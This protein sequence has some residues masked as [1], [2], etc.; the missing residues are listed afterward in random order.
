MQPV[1]F[2]WPMLLGIGILL[3]SMSLSAVESKDQ[4]ANIVRAKVGV[5]V[6]S[7]ERTFSA[8]GRQRLDP[9]DL[10]RLYIHTERACYIYVVHTSQLG[11]SLLNMTEPKLQTTTLI[12]PSIKTYYQIDGSH[13]RETFT[14]VCA[15]KQIPELEAM[16]HQPLDYATWQRLQTRLEEQS[17]LIIADD[18]TTIAIGGNVRGTDL[19]ASQEQLTAGAFLHRVPVSSGDGLLLRSYEFQIQN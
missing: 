15:L 16:E 12:L 10:I 8:R 9:G 17:R 14:V 11:A 19:P 7:K 18:I 6:V 3:F 2:I 13:E 1:R 5:Q 4:E